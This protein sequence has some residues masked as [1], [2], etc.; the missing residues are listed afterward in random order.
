[1]CFQHDNIYKL[2]CIWNGYFYIDSMQKPD[3]THNQCINIVTCHCCSLASGSPNILE[4]LDKKSD[5]V[6][7]VPEPDR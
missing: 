1:M 7:L 2:N 4:R 3:H 6:V 5:N